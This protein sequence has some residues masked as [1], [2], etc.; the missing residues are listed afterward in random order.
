MSELVVPGCTIG[1]L[2]GGQLG[3]MLAMEAKRNGYKV[4]VLD[5]CKDA[6]AALF[7]DHHLVAAFDDMDAA[8]KLAEI[9]DV[10][11]YEFENIDVKI[12]EALEKKYRIFPGSQVLK[13]TQDRFL[14][15]NFF[16][17]NSIPVTDFAKVVTVDDLKKAEES[18]G[19]PA[20][21]KT[22]R[23]GYDGKGQRVIHN[24]EDALEAFEQFK[25]CD[26]IWEKMVDF[27]K[28][29]SV[30]AV[31][32]LDGQVLTYP[33]PHNIHED[34]ILNVSVV[35]AD[36]SD[37]TADE[38]KRVAMKIAE[39]LEIVGTFCVEL[40]VLPDGSVTANEIAPRPHNSGHYTIE[41]CL[42]SQF[43]N[44]MRAICGLP[45][46]STDLLSPLAMVNI[47]G[48][49]SGDDLLGVEDLFLDSNVRLHLYEKT[50]VKNKRKM[51]HLT[52]LASDADEALKKALK[53]RKSLSW[54]KV[55]F[56]KT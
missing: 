21:L 19:F 51:G 38:A 22:C 23:L 43:E 28:E 25:G 32:G 31:R 13:V 24:T 53:A 14:E 52:V 5:P 18:V 37:A 11:T 3:R 50:I 40:F 6:P 39:K 1:I 35:P 15:K 46:G 54:G 30:V 26:L 4:A 56:P 27:E 45:L 36:I 42:V 20:V 9:S 47:L 44:Q 17:E 55:E 33:I 41:G 12:V 49:D 16:R 48:E 29:I 2:G 7:A 34:N 8:L 10:V